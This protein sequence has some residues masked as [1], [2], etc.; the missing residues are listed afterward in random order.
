MRKVGRIR[1]QIVRLE[2]KQCARHTMTGALNSEK[3]A[4]GYFFAPFA[5]WRSPNAF[6][7]LFYSVCANTLQRNTF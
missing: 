7:I 3:R 6:L 2:G 1:F 5:Q 4:R